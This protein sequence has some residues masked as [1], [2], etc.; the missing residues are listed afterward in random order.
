[1][2]KHLQYRIYTDVTEWGLG[3]HSASWA[4]FCALIQLVQRALRVPNR[5]MTK[6]TSPGHLP[7]PLVHARRPNLV[8]AYMALEG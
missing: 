3:L 4:G 8:L 5:P 7:H 6:L 1:M 2:E